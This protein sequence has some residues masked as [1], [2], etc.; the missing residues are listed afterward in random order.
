ML[1]ICDTN[2]YLFNFKAILHGE[3][4]VHQ[5]LEYGEVPW[6]KVDNLYTLC[7]TVLLIFQH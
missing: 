3:G 6:K 1:L 4:E 2:S 5:W 7:M